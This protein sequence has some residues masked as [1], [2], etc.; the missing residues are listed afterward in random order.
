MCWLYSFY[1]WDLWLYA[2]FPLSMLEHQHFKVRMACK[3]EF[4]QTISTD[5]Y[6]LVLLFCNRIYFLNCF[7][8]HSFF[9]EFSNAS[10]Y[11]GLHFVQMPV[12]FR[13]HPNECSGSDLDGDIYFVCWDSEL[14]P[15]RQASPMEYKPA[16]SETLDH[17]VTIE[18]ML[19]NL[20][21]HSYHVKFLSLFQVLSSHPW[22]FIWTI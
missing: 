3:C 22:D 12:T 21:N 2:G 14:I 10:F 15:P 1:A 17:D 16:P 5:I 9:N 7:S 13:P 4:G 18:V 8:M 20:F 6:C 19:R 11:L